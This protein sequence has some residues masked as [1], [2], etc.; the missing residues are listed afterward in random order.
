MATGSEYAGVDDCKMARQKADL[1]SLHL[2]VAYRELG[3]EAGD[4]GGD[5]PEALGDFLWRTVSDH[6]NGLGRGDTH[7]TGDREV[8]DVQVADGRAE[9]GGRRGERLDG[10]DNRVGALGHG[11]DR[12]E[13]DDGDEGDELAEELHDCR[14]V[15]LSVGRWLCKA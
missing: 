5:V 10:G 1:I 6:L 12:A 4:R 11:A 2:R 8:Q 9:G 15:G 7:K 3:V 14:W 13:E